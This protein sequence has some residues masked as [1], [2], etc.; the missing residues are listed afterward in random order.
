MVWA[1]DLDDGTLLKSLTDGMD[2]KKSWINSIPKYPLPDLDSD[3][4]QKKDEL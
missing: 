4:T 3:R 2:R 1:I